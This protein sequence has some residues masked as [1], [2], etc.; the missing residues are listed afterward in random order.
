MPPI[1]RLRFVGT[2]PVLAVGL[3]RQVK[4]DELVEVPGVVLTEWTPP[5]E[6]K[7]VPVLE[8]ADHYLIESGNPPVVRAWPK[9]LWRNETPARAPKPKE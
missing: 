1:V 8:N 6:T 9:T 3:G 4:P 2:V 5:G 7:P